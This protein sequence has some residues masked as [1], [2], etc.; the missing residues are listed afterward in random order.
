MSA[1]G[2][3]KEQLIQGIEKLPEDRL[4]EVLD[5][6]EYLLNKEQKTPVT[7]LRKGLD[8]AKDPILKF[9]GGVSHGSLAKD[10]DKELYGE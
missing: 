10:I 1:G 6:V 4:Q 2:I 8:P 9:I 7:E 5:F 3:L